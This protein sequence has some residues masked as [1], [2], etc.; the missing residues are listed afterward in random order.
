M[1]L[2]V[3]SRNVE[4]RKSWQEKIEEERERLSRHHPGLVHGL[5]VTIEDTSAH[6]SGGF[7]LRV[8][9]SVPN[10][11]VVVKRKGDSVRPLL[12]DAFDTLGL[13]L[14]ELQRKRRQ[15]AKPQETVT[16]KGLEGVIKSLF[17]FESYGFIAT[18]EGREVYFHENALKECTFAELKEGGEI[19][20]GET[21]GDKGPQ[22]S[23][24]KVGK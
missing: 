13:Q 19:R 5:R 4:L 8:V 11:T 18:P 12:V 14:K 15:T 3:E 9:A 6:K 20:F 17:P 24:V 23:W 10:D 21:E 1:E 16:S 7:E 22:A 2:Q